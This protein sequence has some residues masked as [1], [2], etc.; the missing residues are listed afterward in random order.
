MPFLLV[1]PWPVDSYTY[2]D[3][4]YVGGYNWPTAPGTALSFR[5]GGRSVT[6]GG[7]RRRRGQRNCLRGGWPGP[8]AFCGEPTRH[9][10]SSSASSFSPASS[11]SSQV[12]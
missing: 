12:S 5:A 7:G 10:V 1:D 2:D 11:A 3:G 6:M 8:G 9:T 4:T